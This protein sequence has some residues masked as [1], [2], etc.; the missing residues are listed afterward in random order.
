MGQHRIIFQ[1]TYREIWRVPFPA[2]GSF[3]RPMVPDVAFEHEADG[4]S[5]PVIVIDV[6]YCVDQGV[7]DAIAAV[8]MYRD[9]L[10]ERDDATGGSPRHTVG[11]AFIVTPRPPARPIQTI[12]GRNRRLRSF[13]D[14]DIGRNSALAPSR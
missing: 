10:V 7:D 6:K 13:I 8:H 2:V 12:G 9:A 4:G 11:A 3:S 14:R 1:P 5:A